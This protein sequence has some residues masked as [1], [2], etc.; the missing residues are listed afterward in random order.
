MSSIIKNLTERLKVGADFGSPREN[1][2]KWEVSGKK[3]ER[4]GSNLEGF[5]LQQ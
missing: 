5:P 2:L 3:W 4:K 1:R